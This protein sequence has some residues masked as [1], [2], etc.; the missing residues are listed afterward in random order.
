MTARRDGARPGGVQLF[1]N[2]PMQGP[3]AEHLL[4][5][6]DVCRNCLRLVRVERLDPTTAD[7][8]DAMDS[9]YERRRVTTEVDYG[10]AATV[11]EQKGVFCSE[12]GLEDPNER[13]WTDRDFHDPGLPLDEDRFGELCKNAMR[14]LERKGVSIDRHA[15]ATTALARYRD[16]R[17]IDV[18][19]DEATDHGI[20]S[21]AM[22]SANERQPAR[23]D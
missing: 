3:Y 4:D 12:C 5:A 21:A 22:E 16:H 7:G 1:A 17:S 10:P 2:N 11:S 19:F 8:G 13:V 18:C 9:F 23:V 14:S 20:V 6:V 15:F